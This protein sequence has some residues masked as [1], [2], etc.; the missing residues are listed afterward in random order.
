MLHSTDGVA[1][2]QRIAREFS[3]LVEPA[4]LEQPASVEMSLRAGAGRRKIIIDP[5]LMMAL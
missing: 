5:C 4:E 2:R 3:Y 1:L